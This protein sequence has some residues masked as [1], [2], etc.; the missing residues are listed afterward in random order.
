MESR[1][2]LLED[3][4]ASPP[5]HAEL[6]ALVHL[7]RAGKLNQTQAETVRALRARLLVLAEHDNRQ[8]N[9]VGPVGL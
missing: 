9:Q 1:P 4:A 2:A 7:L 5:S 3:A 6:L 8:M